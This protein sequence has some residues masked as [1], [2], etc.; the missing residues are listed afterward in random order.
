MSILRVG[1]L[2]LALELE[3]V[4]KEKQ[5]FLTHVKQSPKD[6]FV[7]LPKVFF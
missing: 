6:F 5:F 2:K 3:G 1:G 4:E 7:L